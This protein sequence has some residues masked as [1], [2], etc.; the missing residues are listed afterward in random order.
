MLHKVLHSACTYFQLRIRA[1]ESRHTLVCV[2][3]GPDWRSLLSTPAR[4][5]GNVEGHAG[6]ISLN[7]LLGIAPVSLHFHFIVY[8]F[9]VD[10]LLVD[11][12]PLLP[13]HCL[14]KSVHLSVVSFAPHV[15]QCS[16]C[17]CLVEY[18]IEC[19]CIPI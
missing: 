13:T 12:L 6:S 4:G 15:V 1:E 3:G 11:G 10:F 7:S 8:A 2:S 16:S 9:C 17:P 18:I 14:V 19:I 5:E